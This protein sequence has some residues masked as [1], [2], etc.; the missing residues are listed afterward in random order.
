MGIFNSSNILQENFT[1]S[2]VVPLSNY[3]E[4]YFSLA[5][6]YC[7]SINEEY[8]TANKVLYKA[9][10]EAG[11]NYEVINESFDGFF[12]K[13][14][15]IVAKF[16]KFLKNLIDKFSTKLHQLV[17]SDKYIT[18]HEKMFGKFTTD[19]EFEMQL[20][21]FTHLEDNNIPLACAQTTFAKEFDKVKLYVNG[22]ISQNVKALT[23]IEA[24]KRVDSLRTAYRE[25]VDSYEDFYD[26][27]RGEVIG[28]RSIDASDYPSELYRKFRDGDDSTTSTTVTSSLV[29]ASLL[30]FKAHEKTVKTVKEI[31]KKLEKDYSEISK[32]VEKIVSSNEEKLTLVGWGDVSNIEVGKFSPE[33]VSELNMIAKAESNKVQQMSTIHLQAMGAKLDAVSACFKQDKALL[34]K[35]L[36][37][38][39]KWK[40]VKKES[41]IDPEDIIPISINSSSNNTLLET[42]S[43]YNMYMTL[44]SYNQ[45][46]MDNYFTE[47]MAIES[48]NSKLLHYISEGVLDSIKEFIEKVI[49]KIKEFFGKIVEGISATF[50]KD[51]TYLKQ[52][53][54]IILNKKNQL[55]T[56]NDFYEYKIKEMVSNSPM[57]VFNYDSQKSYLDTQENFIKNDNT[58]KKITMKAEQSFGDATKFYFMGEPKSIDAEKIN[59]TDLYNFCWD[60]NNTKK[61]LNNELNELDKAKVK[62]IQLAEKVAKE[63]PSSSQSTDTSTTPSQSTDTSSSSSSTDDAKA[64]QRQEIQKQIDELNAKPSLTSA[65]S[66]KLKDLNDKLASLKESVIYSSVYGEYVSEAVL[67]EV[68]KDGSSKDTKSSS[69]TPAAP[70]SNQK[71]STNANLKYGRKDEDLKSSMS[72][73][74]PDDVSKKVNVYF[75]TCSEFLMAKLSVFE[76]AYKDYMWIIREHVKSYAG[77]KDRKNKD[78]AAQTASIT[79]DAPDE[80]LNTLNTD[81]EREEYQQQLKTVK[82][83]WKKYYGTFKGT[84]YYSLDGTLPKQGKKLENPSDKADIM[85][86]LLDRFKETDEYKAYKEYWDKTFKGY[87][88]E[89]RIQVTEFENEPK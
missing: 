71:M 2:S 82:D 62:A 30:R 20:F 36:N 31:Q 89:E 72:G 52:Y 83:T 65:D 9:L 77:D 34:Y 37:E 49:S 61:A 6:E 16:I 80:A 44:E 51:Q 35:A 50:E 28:E 40:N 68:E 74:N 11:D 47:C 64:K 59:M 8:D 18:K 41:A 43:C 22:D 24:D 63:G 67:L 75:N 58:F 76:K 27:F 70:S 3:N 55:G 14:K 66:E 53:K 84:E 39:Q 54:E 81:A 23:A 4:S 86:Q 42:V 17:K 56:L 57:P 69:V 79:F 73:D 25:L 19:N 1:S 15:E 12:T 88:F 7:K 26:V 10:L 85:K 78:H 21:N 38:L 48:G 29:N 45:R 32:H 5:M 60:F 33:V 13:V 87:N 46:K